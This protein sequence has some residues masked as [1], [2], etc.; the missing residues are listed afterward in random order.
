MSEESD[1]ISL[2]S[3]TKG[4]EARS[5][6]KY[7]DSD[8][9]SEYRAPCTIIKATTCKKQSTLLSFVVNKNDSSDQSLEYTDD[10]SESSSKSLDNHVTVFDNNDVDNYSNSIS[11]RKDSRIY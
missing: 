8:E 7:S 11:L 1:C 3:C 5:K 10:N 2:A 9:E 6:R 4:G